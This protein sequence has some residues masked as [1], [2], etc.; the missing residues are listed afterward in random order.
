M[1]YFKRVSKDI[2]KR[3]SVFHNQMFLKIDKYDFIHE[4]LNK[5]SLLNI[6]NDTEFS[7][8]F[9][10]LILDMYRHD[11]FKLFMTNTLKDFSIEEY[12]DVD[13]K[14]IQKMKLIFDNNE[15]IEIYTDRKII[16][17]SIH[18]FNIPLSEISFKNICKYDFIKFQEIL[19]S[20]Y[21]TVSKRHL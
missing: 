7:N 19:N 8:N 21:L 14:I 6:L 12:K 20:I 9:K 11:F 10:I 3:N 15:T 18:Y 1:N 13:S 2:I 16:L 5:N 4:Y 17:N